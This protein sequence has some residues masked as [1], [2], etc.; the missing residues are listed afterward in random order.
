MTIP[1]RS[2]C[3]KHLAASDGCDLDTF[4]QTELRKSLLGSLLKSRAEESDL[5]VTDHSTVLGAAALECDLKFLP[6][7]R[8]G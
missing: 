8:H 4:L 5:S 6:P 7:C 3:L 1:S 2:A